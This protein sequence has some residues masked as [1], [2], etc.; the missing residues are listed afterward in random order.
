M[1]APLADRSFSEKKHREGAWQTSLQSVKLQRIRFVLRLLSFKYREVYQLSKGCKRSDVVLDFGCGGGAYARY[2]RQE[3]HAIVVAADWSFTALRKLVGK[4]SGVLALCAD[5]HRMPIKSGAIDRLFS[6]DTLGHLTDQDAALDE[7]NRICRA[8]GALLLHSECADYRTRWP[9]RVMIRK[10]RADMIALIDGHV[11]IRPAATMLAGYRKRFTVASFY[12]PPGLTGWLT[13]YPEKYAAPL[14]RAKMYLPAAAAALMALGKKMALVRYGLR[15]INM[16]LDTTEMLLGFEGGGSCFAR[17]R[18]VAGPLHGADTHLSLDI[19]VPTWKRSGLLAKEIRAL[20]AQC[21]G[22]DRIFIVWQGEEKPKLSDDGQVRL[23]QL[24]K[25][26][27][28]GARNAGVSAGCNPVVLFL[29][30]DC[31]VYD[32]LLDAHR[33]CYRRGT[34]GAVAGY[35]DDQL[36]GGTFREPSRFNAATGEIF[37]NFNGKESGAAVTLMGANMSFRRTVLDDVGTFDEQYRRNALWEDVDMAFRVLGAGYT[38]HYGSDAAVRHLRHPDGGCRSDTGMRYI[39]NM[40]AN[41]TYFGCTY[42]AGK[43]LF[44]WIHHWWYRLEYIA[45]TKKTKPDALL[46]QR[47]GMGLLA[48]GVAGV[49]AGVLRFVLRGRRRGMPVEVSLASIRHFGGKR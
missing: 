43:D 7:I 32:G 20:R 41:T 10:N 18:T 15:A 22:N 35:I 4:E 28:P 47:Y 5:L 11:A 21:R 24:K 33:E 14:L 29:D 37:Q 23:L 48:A 40:F 8:G 39:Y 42:A 6:I 13:G 17:A 16:L 45:R 27:L 1:A 3:S 26:S 34:A 38:I 9:D 12:S 46:L 25:P 36:F 49:A 31:E 30:D 44:T 2:C 19:V